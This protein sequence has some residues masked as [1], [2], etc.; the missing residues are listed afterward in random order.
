M[1]SGR[2]LLSYL[3]LVAATVLAACSR[4]VPAALPETSYDTIVAQV[5]GTP[6]QR[7]AADSRA[8]WTS[9]LAAVECMR[10]AGYT[11]GIVG[12]NAPLDREY[13]APGDLLAFAPT[14]QDLDVADDVIH[15][16]ASRN[17]LDAEARG[18][19]L[20]NGATD[21]DRIRAAGRCESEAGAVPSRVPDGQQSLATHLVDVLRAAQTSAAPT[22]A[23]DYRT[24]M[25]AVGIPATGLA[26]LRARV[27]RTFPTTTATD[28]TKSPGWASAVEFESRAATAD[29]RCRESIVKAVRVAAAPQL[30]EFARQ[31]AAELDRVAAGWAWIE[32]DALNAEHAAGPED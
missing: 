6:A 3:A 20:D 22:A 27:K 23:A 5:Y 2:G 25:T 26:D 17:V 19:T 10:R 14:R 24:C 1:P 15:A 7:R 28:P 9:R 18:V 8:W 4:A 32:V 29:G 12:Y 16:S 21:L 13:V 11:Y 30:A 31:H